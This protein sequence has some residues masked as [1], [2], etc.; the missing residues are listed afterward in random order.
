MDV[1]YA[2]NEAYVPYLAVSMF[3]LLARNLEKEAV[4]VH[5][6]SNGILPESRER[7][8]ENGRQAAACAERTKGSPVE[9]FQIRFY[10]LGDIRSR[11]HKDLDTGSYDISML[12]RFFIGELLPEEISRVLYLDCDTVVQEYIGGIFRIG[13]KKQVKQEE[14]KE[15]PEEKAEKSPILYG[16]PEPTIYPSILKQLG[17]EGDDAFYINSGVLLIDLEQWRREDVGR[18]LISFYGRNGGRLFCGDQDAINYVL[19]G[20]IGC[21][22]LRYNFFTNYRYFRYKTLTG[23][24]RAYSCCVPDAKS[25]REA[26]SRPAV[27][28]YMGAERPWIRGNRNPYRKAY[29]FWKEQSLYGGQPETRGQEASMGAYHLMNALTWLFPPCRKWI[30]RQFEKKRVLPRLQPLIWE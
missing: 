14:T 13:T 28:H 16:V 4:T 15:M 2:S 11:F 19:K 30:S 17:L 21:L 27:I 18:K 5:V 22:P 25:F 23:L 12:G 20:R 1:C 3:S 8:L 10:E 9:P 24:C 6:I 26:Q 7:L 29:H